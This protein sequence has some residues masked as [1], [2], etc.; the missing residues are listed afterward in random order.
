MTQAA[1][2]DWLR[3]TGLATDE[4]GFVLVNDMLQSLNYPFVFATGDIATMA[5]HPRPKA[6]VFAV[7]QGKPLFHNLRRFLQKQPLKPFHPQTHY[8]SLLNTAD[9]KA[10]AAR[11]AWGWRSPLLWQW[12]NYIDQRFI[13]RLNH[14]PQISSY[15]SLSPSPHLPI[16]PSP[17]SP[18]PSK[19]DS[20][21]LFRVLQRI[22]AVPYPSNTEILLGLNTP[23]A[24]AIVQ[25]P[26]GKVL[27]QAVDYFTALLDDP[28]VFG[29]ISANQALND[30]YAMGAMPQSALAIATVPCGT[31]AK[32]EESLYQLLSG[33]VKVL[34]EA[35]AVL[36][37]GHMTEGAMLAFGLSCNGLADVN[38]LLRK[39]ELQPEHALILTKPLGTG[40]LFAAKMQR[41]ALGRWIDLAVRSMLQS[42][43]QAAFCFLQQQAVA[44]TDIAG[45]G[46]VGHL[47]EMVRA[48]SVAV[49]LNLEA[50]P[51]LPGA[52]ETMAMGILSSLPPKNL[53]GSQFIQN[54]DSVIQHPKFQL[55]FDPQTSG[56]LLAA[57]PLE[58][59]ISCLQ[60][61]RHLGY[62]DSAI[63]GQT[64]PWQHQ[65]PPISIQFNTPA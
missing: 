5:N 11:G 48:S 59:A 18:I 51:I 58:R 49:N 41:K 44:C 64:V 61:L 37:G 38:T 53:E 31:A 25:I 46:L 8:L 3:K 29:Q 2:P 50:I 55:L 26:P 16:P 33:T 36:I 28:F 20:S 42:N 12:K 63:I 30:L 13:R 15:L 10:V 54:L 52:L 23:D 40:T 27:V 35:G 57:V 1:A 56:G 9:G 22:Q 65:N 6:G 45:F 60:H 19:V 7:R 32:V 34:H 17:P 47:L 14:P 43:Q 4:K 21:I 62:T 39:N 24:A